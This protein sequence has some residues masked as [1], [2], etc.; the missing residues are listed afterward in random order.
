MVVLSHI[1]KV[2]LMRFW[3]CPDLTSCSASRDICSSGIGDTRWIALPTFKITLRTSLV[4][5]PKKSIFPILRV[6]HSGCQVIREDMARDLVREM[7]KEEKAGNM[8]DWVWEEN[9]EQDWGQHHVGQL[10]TTV[11]EWNQNGP[12]SAFWAQIWTFRAP[13]RNK[14]PDMMR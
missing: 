3:F 7:V 2:V 10:Q 6:P 9:A 13:G 11:T 5:I 4:S 8:G 12:M 1:S 14:R